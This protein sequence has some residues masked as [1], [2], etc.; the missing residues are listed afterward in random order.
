MFQRWAKERQCVLIC[1]E[2]IAI[3]LESMTEFGLLRE[4]A[5]LSVDETALI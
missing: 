5:G 2:G 1:P 3:M 4:R